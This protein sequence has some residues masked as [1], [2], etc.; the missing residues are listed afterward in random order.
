MTKVAKKKPRGE[1][2]HGKHAHPRLVVIAP[3]ETV[4][5]WK[6][7]AK[8]AGLTLSAWARQA[9]DSQAETLTPRPKAPRSSQN[10]RT[11][12]VNKP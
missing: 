3:R 6:A 11:R 10:G 9:L 1:S 5:R 2:R 7:A 8:V 12:P 4:D